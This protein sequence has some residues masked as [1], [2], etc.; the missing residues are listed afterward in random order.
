MQQSVYHLVDGSTGEPAKCNK[1]IHILQNPNYTHSGDECS[2]T[3]SEHTSTL[4][5]VLST[6]TVLVVPSWQ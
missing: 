6:C 5:A 4:S 1:E 2:M 3:E